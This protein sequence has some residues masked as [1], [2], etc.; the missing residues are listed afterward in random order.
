MELN[1]YYKTLYQQW[2]E[3]SESKTGWAG[4]GWNEGEG[5][6]LV[7]YLEVDKYGNATKAL[8]KFT[9][10]I[11]LGTYRAAHQIVA[12]L[13]HDYIEIVK[14]N[15]GISRQDLIKK[16]PKFEK[17]SNAIDVIQEKYDLKEYMK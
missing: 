3:D 16:N 1:G 12:Q 7:E 13:L 4:S 8:F 6:E 15:E 17:I 5:Y 14:E 10:R 11:F 9:G 2:Q